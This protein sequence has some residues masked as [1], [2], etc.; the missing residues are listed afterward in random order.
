M[1]ETM[2]QKIENLLNVAF[3][4]TEDELRK[5]SELDAGYNSADNTWEIII[6][7]SG[8]LQNIRDKYRFVYFKELLNYYAI[9][10]TDKKTIEQLANEPEVDFIE[11]S[12]RMYFELERAKSAACINQISNSQAQTGL[13]GE[14]VITAVIDSGIDIL[15]RAFRNADGTTRI[16][17]IY[18]QTTGMEYSRDDINAVI[19]EWENGQNPDVPAVDLIGHG[20]DVALIAC[21]NDGVAYR[22]DII[23]VKLGMSVSGSFPRTT[24]IM[25]GVDYVIRKA[26]QYREPVAVNLSY[27]NNY[28]DHRGNTIIENYLNSISGIYKCCICVGSGNEADKPIHCGGKLTDDEIRDIEIAV[29]TYET[30]LDIQIWKNYWDEVDFE[31]INPQGQSV[32]RIPRNGISRMRSGFTEI[33]T[34][35][36]EPAPFNVFQEIY[37]NLIP[38]EDFITSGVWKIRMIPGSIKSGEFNMWLPASQSINESTGFIYPQANDTYT[39]P[40]TTRNVISVGAYDANIGAYAAFSGRGGSPNINLVKPDLVAPG[41]GIRVR[42]NRGRGA[43]TVKSVTGTSYAA[44]FVTGASALLMQWGIVQGNDPFLYGDKVKAYFIKGAAPM[45]GAAEYPNVQTGWGMLCVSKSI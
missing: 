32:G 11:K 3:D 8:S 12:K 9:I 45:S 37:I 2:N 20:T 30:G 38:T 23:A 15:D 33:L 5:S 7:Y 6:K 1:G 40:S 42:R 43:Q 21:G 35:Y 14:N 16:I 39:V 44:P 36:G 26:M 17:N 34:L 25:D 29:G 4:A 22:S 18:D 10:I 24:N 41:V 19:L 31:I 13:S 27:G 28:G